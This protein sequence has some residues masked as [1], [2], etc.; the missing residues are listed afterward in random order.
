MQRFNES[1][2]FFAS[3]IVLLQERGATAL[4]SLPLSKIQQFIR[5]LIN[6]RFSNLSEQLDIHAVRNFRL[7]TK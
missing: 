7:G 6:L 1:E 5:F 4:T 3:F 2:D